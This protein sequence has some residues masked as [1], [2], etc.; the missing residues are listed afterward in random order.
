MAVNWYK[1]NRKAHYWASIVIVVPILI[2]S[3]TGAMLMLKKQ[4][5][6]IQPE[7]VRGVGKV[8]SLSF[9]QI[10]ESAKGVP[11]AR[12]TSWKNIKRLDVR[13]GKGVV[14]IRAKNGWEIQADLQ[15]GKVLNRAFRRSDII[16]SI[17]DGSY[18]HD[19]IKL[20]YFL[21]TAVILIFLCIT[22]LYL[23]YVPFSW[24]KRKKQKG[25][26]RSGLDRRLN[27]EEKH[28]LAKERIKKA[29]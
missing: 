18:F 13:P 1:F 14:K 16:E 6:W 26:R 15:T 9:N 17:H 29:A 25:D 27:V 22:G 5:P 7:T 21:P 11:E 23:F 10:L 12:I 20:G 2:I 4:I 28:P 3:V 8:P 19:Y 24:K